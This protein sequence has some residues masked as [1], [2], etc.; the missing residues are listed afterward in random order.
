MGRAALI[1]EPVPQLDA[2]IAVMR[3]SG[4]LGRQNSSFLAEWGL[5]I[6]QYNV[7]R[8]LYVRDRP[9]GLRTREVGDVMLSRAPD[10]TRLVDR[11]CK[12]GLVDRVAWPADR[13]VVAL[14]LSQ[15][16]TELVEEMHDDM[17]A[18][19][20]ELLAPI[21]IELCKQLTQ[22]SAAVLDALTQPTEDE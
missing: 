2:F 11:L 13:R 9:E 19:H 18:H 3:L 17:L 6:E 5:T 15:V 4:L 16:G 20:R 1:E 21:S 14:R 10:I 7:L 22:V 8:V 12:R